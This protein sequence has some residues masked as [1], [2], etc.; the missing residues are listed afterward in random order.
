M[1]WHRV[2]W[3][4]GLIALVIL[5]ACG[6][7]KPVP[8]PTPTRQLKP[9]FTPTPPAMTEPTSPPSAAQPTK[10]VTQ[11][12]A[13]NTPTSTPVPPTETPTPTWTPTPRPEV[14]VQTQRLNVRAGPNILHPRVGQVKQGD[15][16]EVIGKNPSGSWWQVRLANG[17]IGW[18]YAKL[19][20]E[21]GPTG[22]VQVAQNI[23]TPPPTPTWTPTPRPTPTP[24]PS[25]VYNKAV[26]YNCEPNA[27]ITE[28][29]GTVYYN[30]QPHNG[31]LVV[32]STRPDGPWVTKPVISGPHPGYPDW[33]AGF[34]SHIIGWNQARGGDW[35]FWIVDESGKRISIIAKVHTDDVAGPG[36]CQKWTLDWDT[37]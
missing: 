13:T 1:K 4:T 11:P 33:N 17:T 26:L 16:L 12:Q 3:L 24:T 19:V 28:V 35:Y 21:Q 8:T 14:V 25:Y 7:P 6:S 22:D 9:T 18:V 34:Y 36:K 30:H 31:A 5:A 20:S 10:V 32:F 29:H 15:V 2:I 27:G 37:N 23:P